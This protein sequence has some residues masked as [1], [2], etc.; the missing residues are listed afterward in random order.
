VISTSFLK[1]ADDAAWKDDPAIKAWLAFMDK[2]Y[3]EGD[4][5]MFTRCLAMRRPK[6]CFSVTQCG[7]DL[8]RENGHATGGVT[9][10]LP[11]P[12]GAA[13][14]CDQHRPCGFRP[15]SSA[16]S[17]VDGTAWSRWRRDRKR[18][19]PTCREI[20]SAASRA[21][22]AATPPRPAAGEVEAEG[23]G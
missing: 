19:L 21:G 2:Y 14:H 4:R 1:D 11:K 10:E 17:A 22:A 8:S 16:A 3:P 9:E 7:D 15:S 12:G 13:G 18:R 20:L 5:E 23:F 6:P